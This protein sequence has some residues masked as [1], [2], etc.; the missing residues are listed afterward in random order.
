MGYVLILYNRMQTFRFSPIKNKVQLI[1]AI[2]YTACKTSELCERITGETFPIESLTIFSHFYVEYKNLSEILLEIGTLINE[3]N[4][5]RVALHE[6]IEVNGNTII[7][8]RI[9]KPDEER[10]QV[11]CNDFEIKD[12]E[13][14]KAKYL[15]QHPQNLRCIV[16]ADYEMIEFFDPSYD[17]LAYVV[18]VH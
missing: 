5:P 10:P 3:N 4:G 8:L 15:S 17:V 16:R 6:P 9:R 18:S 13:S 11:G 1:E 12:Y 2:K 14:F 7:H